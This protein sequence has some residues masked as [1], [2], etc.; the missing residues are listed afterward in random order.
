MN[1]RESRF[2]RSEVTEAARLKDSSS[3]FLD[4]ATIYYRDSDGFPRI[5]LIANDST[6]SPIS[7]RARSILVTTSGGEVLLVPGASGRCWRSFCHGCHGSPNVCGWKWTAETLNSSF[8]C[9]IFRRNFKLCQGVVISIDS[10]PD[11]AARPRTS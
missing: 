6:G 9:S 4:A 1:F 5:F 11:C 2:K 7:S 3:S 8:E 10:A